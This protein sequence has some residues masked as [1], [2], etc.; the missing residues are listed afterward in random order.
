METH[1]SGVI[2]ELSNTDDIN[3]IYY[4]IGPDKESNPTRHERVIETEKKCTISETEL[5]KKIDTILQKINA[6]YEAKR[7]KDILLQLPKITL[8]DQ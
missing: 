4:T 5:S 7:K 3:I 2:N 1:I 8:V 6:D